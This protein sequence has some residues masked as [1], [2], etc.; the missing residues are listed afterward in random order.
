MIKIQNLTKKIDD[1]FIFSSLNLEIPSNKVTSVVGESGIGKTTLINLIAGFTKKDSGNIS[2]FDENGSEIKKPLVDVVFQDFNL[3]E[4]ITS[5]DNILIGNNVINKLLDKNALNQN[6]NLMSIKTEQLE[7]KVNNLSGGERQRIAILRSLSRDSSFILLDE[8]TRNLDIENAKIVFENLANIAKNKT[9]LVVSH[10]LDLAKKYA[11]KIV[12][13]EKNKISEEI[14]DKN[15]QNQSLITKDTAKNSDLKHQNTAK[16]SKLSKIKQEFKT[17]FLLTITDFKSKLT[18]SILFLLLFL[19]S[20]FG[21]LLFGVLNLNISSTNLQNTIEYQ[22]DS[23]VITKKPNAEI[24]TFSTDEITKIQEKNPKIV[25]IVPIFSF[26]KVTFTYG[27]K[28]EFDSSVDYIDESNFFKNRFIFDN[29]NLV[30]RN[31]QNKDEVIISKS[32][33]TKFNIEQPNNQ[34]ISVSSFRNTAVD[35]KVVGISSL[36]TL[37]RLNFSFLHHKFFELAKPVQKISGPNENLDNNKPEKIDPWVLKLYFN[38]DDDLANNIE[39]FAKN[40]KEF[41]IQ[42]SLGGITKSILNTQSFTNIVIGAILVLFVII[43]LIQ[44]VF[45]AK[46][47]SDSKMKLIGILK[48]L[49][50]KTWQIFF[51]HWLNIIIISLFILFINSVVFLPSMGKIYTAIIGQDIL[52]PSLSQV[53]ALLIIIWLI[54][55]ASISVIYLI[56][57]W[58]SYRKPVIKLLKFEQF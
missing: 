14:F 27:D 42:S 3:I 6:A 52:L 36:S 33:A 30:G 19:T 16:N 47:L 25:K 9:I 57:S 28:V 58:L 10:N 12:Y 56:I 26:P 7:Q 46:N 54:M 38:I 35:L 24:N 5:N 32:L 15:G 21:T 1:R 31:I 11:D 51:Y 37:D 50:A 53:G 8:P 39:N 18:S 43:L 17:G 45:Y 49:N 23:V 13:I 22:L 4:K 55:F 40:N 2:F 29:K 44:T 41:E 20:F 34:K 48:A